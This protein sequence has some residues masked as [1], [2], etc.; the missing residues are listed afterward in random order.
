MNILHPVTVLAVQGNWGIGRKSRLT[1]DSD[2]DALAENEAI[3]A[4]EDRNLSELVELHVV[5]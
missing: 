1:V 2:S 3:C 4:L 5:L